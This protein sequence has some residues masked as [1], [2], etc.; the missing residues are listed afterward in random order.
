MREFIRKFFP[1]ELIRIL[2]T[3]YWALYLYRY[4][5]QI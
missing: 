3:I 5:H 1:E 4:Y 2:Q